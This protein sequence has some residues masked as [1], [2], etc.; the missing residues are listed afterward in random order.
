[1]PKVCV[2]GGGSFG[3]AMA[4]ALACNGHDVVLL[5]RSDDSAE[6][7]NQNHRNQKYMKEFVLPD[8]IRATTDLKEALDGAALIVHAVPMQVAHSHLLSL[9]FEFL[10]LIGKPRLS[11]SSKR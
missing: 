6:S 1:M 3:T 11:F 9:F 2:F 4:F 5:C 10:E 8:N 7:I